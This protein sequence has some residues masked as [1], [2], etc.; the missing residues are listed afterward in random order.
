MKAYRVVEFGAP[1]VA[2]DL[3][4]PIATGTQVVVDV[5][6]CGLCQSD[7]HFH[8][9]RVT[10]EGA[11]ALKLSDVGLDVPMTL[12]HEIYGR[13]ASFGADAG[14]FSHDI[15]RPVIVYP[16]I[17]CGHCQACLSGRDNECLNPENLG[18]Q[19]PG[20]QGEK[21][22]VRETKFLVDAK[23]INPDIAGVY[24]CSGLTA[25][26]ALAKI[27]SRHGWIGI[28]GMGGVGLMGL[29]IAKGIGFE[30][31]AVFDIDES[32]LKLAKQEYGADL[33]FNTRSG[34]AA[35]LAL[36]TTGGIAAVVDFV[37]SEATVTFALGLLGIAG[38]YI[39][40]GLAGGTLNLPLALLTVKH[41]TVR[42]SYVGTLAELNA[43]VDHVRKGEIK[44]IPIRTTPISCVNEGIA[45][46]VGRLVYLQDS[47]KG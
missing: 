21:V 38:T 32:K 47:A 3:P 44:P 22:V 35:S 16:W 20:G 2:Q 15:G 24:A 8:A 27:P 1:I 4:D 18:L 31:V 23:G 43:V 13:I 46:L 39:N 37:G 42:G 11:G 14:L 5:D 25:Y 28:I 29:A 17:G 33:A 40:V 6:A 12:G 7:L 9:G 45:E 10:G 34:T 26:S 19:R 36:E 30:Q 41:L